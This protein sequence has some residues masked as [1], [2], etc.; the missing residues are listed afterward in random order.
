MSFDAE[1]FELEGRAAS[2]EVVDDL[3]TSCRGAGLT[4]TSPQVR[5]DV[6]GSWAFVLRGGPASAGV[7]RVNE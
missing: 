6:D 5:R 2:A 7:A 1:R 4:V 3:V